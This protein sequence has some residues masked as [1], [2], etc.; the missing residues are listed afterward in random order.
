MEFDNNLKTY[1]S[2]NIPIPIVNIGNED[3]EIEDTD[4]SY[5]QECNTNYIHGENCNC[6]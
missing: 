3:M 1:K 2:L 4:T 5:C 6:E